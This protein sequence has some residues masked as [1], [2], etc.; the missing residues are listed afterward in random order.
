MFTRSQESKILFLHGLVW[1]GLCFSLVGTW[2]VIFGFLG[3]F[4]SCG[5]WE[6]GSKGIKYRLEPCG[7]WNLGGIMT[8]FDIVYRV[9]RD[10][11]SKHTALFEKR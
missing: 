6:V 9:G 11:K 7:G 8:L 2:N 10:A 1:I 3:A 4:G 5:G